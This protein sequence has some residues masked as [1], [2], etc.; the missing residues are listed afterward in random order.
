MSLTICDLGE[1]SRFHFLDNLLRVNEHIFMFVFTNLNT[2]SQVHF[3]TDSH[4]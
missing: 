4:K 1:K 3:Y 2:F